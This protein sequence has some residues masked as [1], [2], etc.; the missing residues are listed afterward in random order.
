MKDQ[1]IPV[2]STTSNF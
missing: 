2:V 1:A